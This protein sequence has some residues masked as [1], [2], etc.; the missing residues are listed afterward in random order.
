MFCERF[1]LFWEKWRVTKGNFESLRQWWE[2][3]KA[4]IR[5][6]CQQYT[7]LSSIE[8]KEIIRALEQDIKSIEL[9][10]LTQ[11]DPGLVMKLQNK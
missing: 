5:L 4:Q 1:L 3:G 6:F 7:A 10:L 9:K 2:V 8:V 11:N